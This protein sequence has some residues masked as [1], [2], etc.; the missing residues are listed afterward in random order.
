MLYDDYTKLFPPENSPKI[1]TFIADIERCLV[2]ADMI[3][4]TVQ[5]FSKLP[6]T[7][8]K[9]IKTEQVIPDVVV[10]AEPSPLHHLK[11]RT[12]SWHPTVA[13]RD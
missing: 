9:D 5:R 12:L 1:E 4:L 8:S 2:V 11:V 6:P 3:T 13:P 10:V 7:P